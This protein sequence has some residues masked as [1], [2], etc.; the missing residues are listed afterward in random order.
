MKTITFDS[1]LQQTVLYDS[2]DLFIRWFHESCL[3]ESRIVFSK[4]A[5]KNEYLFEKKI[6]EQIKTAKP[7]NEKN[8][9]KKN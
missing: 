5:P 7:F 3:D 1:H 9:E 6:Y 4:F 2:I 8:N